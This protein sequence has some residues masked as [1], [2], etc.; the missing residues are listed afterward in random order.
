MSGIKLPELDD[1][2][3]LFDRMFRSKSQDIE[4]LKDKTEK[5]EQEY[6]EISSEQK[7]S[8]EQIKQSEE[9]LKTQKKELTLLDDKIKELTKKAGVSEVEAHKWLILTKQQLQVYDKL[10]FARFN[11]EKHQ[12]LAKHIELMEG[13]IASKLYEATIAT[14]Q[15]CHTEMMSLLPKVE[16]EYQEAVFLEEELKNINSQLTTYI[17]KD[18]VEQVFQNSDGEDVIESIPIH[19]WAEDE[20]C[21]VLAC[22]REIDT[23]MR[24]VDKLKLKSMQKLERSMDSLN[25]MINDAIQKALHRHANSLKI[26]DMQLNIAENL[27]NSGFEVVDNIYEYNDERKANILLLENEREEK[28]LT[29]FWI[30]NEQVKMEVD[31]NTMNI[32][33]HS[34]RFQNILKTVG[35]KGYEEMPGYENKPAEA[36]RFD[37]KRFQKESE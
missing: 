15:M 3:E 19:F 8:L 36:E 26:M 21:E 28:I 12:E 24:N 29:K 20:W 6:K 25:V 22:K 5:L 1:F 7:K 35:A 17:K 23:Q 4:K 18:S 14:G 33:T 13:N 30:E 16:Q 32:F 31:F 9:N 10:L 2:K 34:Q 37:L 27:A 11:P